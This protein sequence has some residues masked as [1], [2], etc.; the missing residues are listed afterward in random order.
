[1]TLRRYAPLALS[2]IALACQPEIDERA[3]ATTV[4]YAVF[5]PAAS[6][7]PLP[8]D[9]ALS[10]AAA[11][12]PGGAAASVPCNL[13]GSLQNIGLCA[14]VRAG[15]FPAP[16][17]VEITFLRGTLGSDGAVSYAPAPS[18]EALDLATLAFAGASLA[19]T[20]GV[21]D[22]TAGAPITTAT[23]A[24]TAAA[25]K[26]TLTAPGGAWTAGHQYAVLVLGGARG[27]TTLTGGTYTAMPPFYILREAVIADLDLSLPENQGLFPGDA[28]A[29]AASGTALEAL[30]ANYRLLYVNAGPSLVALNLPFDQVISL[31][32][33]QIAPDATITV[34]DADAS[35]PAAFAVNGGGAPVMID[36]FTLQSSVNIATL[37]SVVFGLTSGSAGLTNLFVS[38]A[39]DCSGT[40]LGTSAAN[41]ADG[42]V[43]I[44]FTNYLSVGNTA[45]VSLYVCATT[46]S[47][48]APTDVSG[49][50]VVT[51]ANAIPGLV[52]VPAGSDTSAVLTVNPAP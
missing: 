35:D 8:N 33:F 51:S 13:A 27:P 36:A 43:P 41:P 49:G 40:P 44:P 3:N 7:I 21:I 18:A 29:K 50:I 30:R 5:N 20:L 9:I 2:A 28:A 25:G 16:S 17:P 52:F 37:T 1:M 34:G 39:N 11:F 14:Y 31:Q 4:D 47:P 32:T 38:A 12:L 42:A 48:A 6:Q 26:L 23:P 24:F 19:P 46:K 10:S 15:G 45:A 22:L